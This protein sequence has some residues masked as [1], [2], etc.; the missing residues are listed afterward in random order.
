MYSQKAVVVLAILGVITASAL[1]G[2]SRQKIETEED[3]RRA[4]KELSNAGRW[5]KDDEKGASNFITPAKR[6][7]AALL[8]KEGISVSLAHA[9]RQEG[10]G[11]KL[12]RTLQPIR[13]GVS[14]MDEYTMT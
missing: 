8:V 6:K 5:G 13:E 1:M 3:F 9:M 11:A 12:V 2:Q 10:E 4:M 14:I 7:Q